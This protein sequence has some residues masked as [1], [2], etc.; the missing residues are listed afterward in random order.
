MISR[1]CVS[2]TVC[3]FVRRE[4]RQL[5]C[6]RSSVNSF[7]HSVH[8][9]HTSDTSWRRMLI[10]WETD[11]TRLMSIFVSLR[12]VTCVK[13]ID[14]SENAERSCRW[15]LDRAHVSDVHYRQSQV[16]I[17]IE[18][19]CAD[20]SL[21]AR[22]CIVNMWNGQLCWYDR[23]GQ[24]VWA[25]FSTLHA[26]QRRC[27]LMK[28]RAQLT[29]RWDDFVSVWLWSIKAHQTNTEHAIRLQQITFCSYSQ[30]I[31]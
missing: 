12:S 21:G 1:Q 25:S 24:R 20:F 8:C 28:N 19:V 30:L 16:A 7:F 29:L 27:T 18:S 15:L 5:V 10:S 13:K 9:Q 2:C 26:T 17:N 22:Q 11:D 4:R 3:L 31:N 23:A 6:T 14:V